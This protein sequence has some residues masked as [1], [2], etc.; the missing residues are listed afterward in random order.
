MN[1]P[2]LKPAASAGG[3]PIGSDS[4]RGFDA[5]FHARMRF[6]DFYGTGWPAAFLV[7][8]LLLCFCPIFHNQT[9]QSE[10]WKTH[11]SH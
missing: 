4:C 8:I 5:A 3:T 6:T 9:M 11:Q 2:E 7:Q 1:Q 10:L